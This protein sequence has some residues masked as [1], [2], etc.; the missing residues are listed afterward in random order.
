MPDR[1]SPA[2][3]ALRRHPQWQSGIARLTELW[4]ARGAQARADAAGYAQS[5]EGT[6]GLMVVDVVMSANRGYDEVQRRVQ[7]YADTG[8]ATLQDV[9]DNPPGRSFLGMRRREPDTVLAVATA[10]LGLCGPDGAED[11]TCLTWAEQTAGMQHAFR[12]EPHVGGISGI[13]LALFCYLRMRS[14]ADG[15]K[16]DG[17]VRQALKDLGLPVSRDPHAILTVAQCAAVEL[18]VAELE[19]DQLLWFALGADRGR[20]RK[21]NRA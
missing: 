2:L 20:R 19:L 13:G 14:G 21:V 7:K 16:P 9:V 8:V 4:E 18:G 12:V 5:Y 10:L 11:A 15:I 1:C 6:R 3:D 17:R